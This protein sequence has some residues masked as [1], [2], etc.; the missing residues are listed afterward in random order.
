MGNAYDKRKAT[1]A[2]HVVRCNLLH[3]VCFFGGPL[4]DTWS[5]SL[6]AAFCSYLTR[7]W[8]PSVSDLGVGRK[9]H[10]EPARVAARADLQKGPN[11]IQ[12]KPPAQRHR[13]VARGP[14]EILTA[15][16]HAQ[17][18]GSDQEVSRERCGARVR[19]PSVFVAKGCRLHEGQGD[20]KARLDCRRVTV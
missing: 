20:A 8:S 14:R 11:E 15:L 2:H 1:A 19:S 12:G 16:V 5:L 9:V 10:G 4:P 17:A 3:D 7:G 13:E 18:E 6:C